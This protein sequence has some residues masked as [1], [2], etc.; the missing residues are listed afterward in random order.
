MGNKEIQEQRMRGYFI[1]ATK[2]ILKGEGLKGVSV[3]NIASQA[4]YSFATL[5]NYFRDVNEL[6][7]LCVTDFQEECR[8]FVGEQT[9]KTASGKEKL[10]LTVQAYINYFIEYP[11]IFDL[12]YIA[13]VGDLGNKQS[14]INLISNS[15]DEICKSE[16]E[17]CINNQLVDKEKSEIIKEQLRYMVVG[18][19]LLYLNRMT[20]DS[21]SDF[22]KKAKSQI[23]NIL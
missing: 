20:P 2:D 3:R 22:I 15:L 9:K 7:F 10:K 4:G 21:Y 13:R 23:D 1:Q 16:W 14:T 19:L 6:V 5:Y 11:G 18:M 12:F 17:Y 8:Q